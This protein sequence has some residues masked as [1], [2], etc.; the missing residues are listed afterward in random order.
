[1]DPV[2]EREIRSSFV[3][4]SKGD[5][6]RLHVPRNL[7]E[8]PWD[9]LDFLGWSDPTLPGRCY[10][11]VPQP[12]R[13]VGVAMRYQ[14]GGSG[15]TQMCTICAT[16]HTGHGVSLMT[17][18][19]TG[20]SGRAGNSIGTYMC[21]DLS[22]SLYARNKKRPALGTRYREDL[23]IEQKAQRIHANINAFLTRLGG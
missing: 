9:D 23:T 22:C 5:A 6:K 2:T 12:D 16:T 15:R 7:A 13:L 19:K 4:C 10:L 17:A 21:T 8:Q 18:S 3:N 1:M 14:G 11:V 20:E